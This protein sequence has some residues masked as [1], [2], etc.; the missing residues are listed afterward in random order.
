LGE[1]GQAV[2]P[3]VCFTIFRLK[4]SQDMAK[5]AMKRCSFLTLPKLHVADQVK[6]HLLTPWW[7]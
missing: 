3:G 7:Q 5:N 4:T 6:Q 1:H 2:P